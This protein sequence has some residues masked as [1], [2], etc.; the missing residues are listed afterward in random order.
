MKEIHLLGKKII[1]DRSKVLL[2]YKP[3]PDWQNY[4]MPMG[5]HWEYQD[6]CLI[7]TEAGNKGG[8][9][10]SKEAF[11]TNVM[12][13]FTVSTVLPATR[14][15]NA[16][17]CAHWD[18]E[19]DYLGESYVCG[20]N[21]WYEHKSGIERNNIGTSNLYA[22]TS[23]YQYEPGTEVRICCG[24]IDGHCFMLVDDCMVSEL[25]DPVPIKGGHVGFS[26]YCTKLRIKDIEIREIYYEPFVQTYEAEF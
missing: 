20:L 21:G 13:T 7:G 8:I 2:D 4:W 24:A 11:D 6:G 3:G 17:F 9:L 15:L 22:T 14:D 16:V 5:G 1:L 12:L 25:I 23:H 18:Q 10:F 19:T 26:P